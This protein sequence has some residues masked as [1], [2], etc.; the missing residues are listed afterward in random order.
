[1][2]DYGLSCAIYIH[3][4]IN[5]VMVLDASM[6]DIILGAIYGMVYMQLFCLGSLVV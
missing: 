5:M 3:S 1:M 6:D 4:C 2:F